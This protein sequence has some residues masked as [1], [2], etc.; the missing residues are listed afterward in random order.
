MIYTCL[1][2]NNILNYTKDL[3]Q[4]TFKC[5]D[6]SNTISD[7]IINFMYNRLDERNK[8]IFPFIE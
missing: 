2:N 3:Q 8:F 5:E 4:I 7:D 1:E 6:L